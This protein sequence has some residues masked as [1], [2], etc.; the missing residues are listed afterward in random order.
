M[1]MHFVTIPVFDSGAAQAE[2]N[3]F[4]GG[5]RVLAVERQ[6]VADGAG[7][8]WAVCVSYVDRPG[9][10]Q[11]GSSGSASSSAT[12]PM[13]AAKGK[14]RRGK[15]DYREVLEPAD[16]EL[17][18]RL[19]ELRKT[20][21]EREGVPAY[22]V[23]TNE[24]LA[25]LARA[26]PRTLAAVGRIPG[27]GP[28]RVEKYAKTFLAA[29]GRDGAASSETAETTG[30]AEA[31]VV[32]ELGRPAEADAAAEAEAEAERDRSAGREIASGGPDN[33]S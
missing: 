5:H 9:V 14:A 32:A 16:F 28:A 1:R 25:G 6:L 17:F 13:I 11:A 31:E 7:S 22:A 2:L 20:I 12:P 33:A 26:R 3:R 8:A 29:L 21:A 24:Q 18:A 15:V 27:V 10:S 23:F 4:L 30:P 19:R